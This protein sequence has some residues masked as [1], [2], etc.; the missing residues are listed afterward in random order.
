MSTGLRSSSTCRAT[1]AEAR[2]PSAGGGTKRPAHTSGSTPAPPFAPPSPTART[3]GGPADRPA[4][5]RPAPGGGQG[6]SRSCCSRGRSACGDPGSD[7]RGPLPPGLSC[8]R[9]S[10][11][12]CVPRVLLRGR[13][14]PAGSQEEI[15]KAVLSVGRILRVG[16]KAQ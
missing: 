14:H 7:Y 5:R 1:G 4:C 15:P 9:W 3:R 10:G 13:S 2:P 12:E 6:R 16:G 11:E 8:P